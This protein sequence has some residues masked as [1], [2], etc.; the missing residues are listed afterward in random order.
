MKLI[1]PAVDVKIFS[2]MSKALKSSSMFGNFV[3]NFLL[4]IHIVIFFE[5]RLYATSEWLY[6]FFF[7]EDCWVSKILFLLGKTLL[8]RVMIIWTSEKNKI[9]TTKINN[10]PF[11]YDSYHLYKYEDYYAPHFTETFFYL[12]LHLIPNIIPIFII[13]NIPIQSQELPRQCPVDPRQVCSVLH[14]RTLSNSLVDGLHPC[15]FIRNRSQK[16]K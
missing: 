2:G 15:L 6:H 13:D 7:H 11:I 8:H 4:S 1:Y 12:Y 14:V 9:S 10:T 3:S 16:R 5:K